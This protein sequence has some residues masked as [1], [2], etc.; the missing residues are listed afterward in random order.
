M[1][2]A[3]FAHNP[4]A[5]RLSEVIAA[6]S[7]ALDLTE[8]QPPGHALRCA[9]IGTRMGQSLGLSGDAQADLLYTLLLK[10]TGCRQQR[11]P[12]VAAVWR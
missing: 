9:W 5:L 10:D 3:D 7:F 2:T 6:L 1:A 11:R 8:G 12:A 4:R